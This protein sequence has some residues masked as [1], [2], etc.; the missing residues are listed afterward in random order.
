MAYLYIYTHINIHIYR[1]TV[2][3]NEH[4]H[5]TCQ[6]FTSCNVELLTQLT[7]QICGNYMYMDSGLLRYYNVQQV[8]RPCHSESTTFL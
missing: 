8:N 1:S 3:D 5:A 2:Q 6:N 4:C 7:V